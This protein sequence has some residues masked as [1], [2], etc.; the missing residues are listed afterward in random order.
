LVETST[1]LAVVKSEN[2]VTSIAC[3]LRSSVDSAKDS[4]GD[5]M[6]SI[7]ELAG[8]KIELSGSYPGWKPNMNSGILK[9]MQSVYNEKWGKTPE[10]KAVHAGL[11]CGILGANYPNWDMISFGSTILYLHSP[12]EKV[13]IASVGKFWEFLAL[14]L[15]NVK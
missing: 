12:D 1:N 10:I 14:T 13:N 7:C 2:G 15:A 3:L 4:L 6:V 9:T 5:M 11:E 8:V